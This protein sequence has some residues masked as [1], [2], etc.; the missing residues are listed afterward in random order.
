MCYIVIRSVARGLPLVRSNILDRGE[1]V[2][3]FFPFDSLIFHQ[4]FALSKLFPYF[5]YEVI[6]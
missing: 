1:N 2:F 5:F 6:L 4:N 3:F